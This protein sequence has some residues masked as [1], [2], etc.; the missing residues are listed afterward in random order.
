M[1]LQTY[2]QM[3]TITLG[4][5]F[6]N[7]TIENSHNLFN[8]PLTIN[9][10]LNDRSKKSSCSLDK[11]QKLKFTHSLRRDPLFLIFSGFVPF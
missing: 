11:I 9:F 8:Q 3:I 5:I 1:S 6:K 10:L 4:K 7:I 2:N